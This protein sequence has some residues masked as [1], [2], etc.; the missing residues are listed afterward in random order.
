M[1]CFKMNLRS[2]ITLLCEITLLQNIKT[3]FQMTVCFVFVFYFLYYS[4][5]FGVLDKESLAVLVKWSVILVSTFSLQGLQNCKYAKS[6]PFQ[7]SLLKRQI[8]T[9]YL[10]QLYLWLSEFHGILLSIQLLTGIFQ[11]SL[12]DPPAQ[13]SIV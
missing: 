6:Q 7:I 5:T 1:C 11:N 12:K 2:Q 4:W 13:L 10:S 9:Q 8:Q 3:N